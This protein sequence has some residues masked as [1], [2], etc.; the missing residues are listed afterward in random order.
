MST[1]I[2]EKSMNLMEE[3]KAEELAIKFVDAVYGNKLLPREKTLFIEMAKAARL[4]PFTRE[5]HIVAY[6]EGEYRTL[7]IITGYEVY[8]KRAMATGLVEYWNTEIV[9]EDT[10]LPDEDGN[11][12]ERKVY[13]PKCVITIK[14]KDWEKEWKHEISFR[15]FAQFKW[16]KKAG[17]KVLNA[18]WLSKPQFMLKKVGLGQ[19]FRWLF[20][21]YLSVLPYTEEESVNVYQ[22][23]INTEQA[24]TEDTTE[25]KTPKALN[26]PLTAE[27]IAQ[28]TVQEAAD[29]AA[30]N[31]D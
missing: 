2:V 5:I 22:N 9:K 4:N 30:L 28:F 25:G 29:Y 31:Q 24:I 15:E 23:T 12:Q 7:S 11:V 3:S 1:D 21:D 14:R 10:E 13:N 17:K 18:M 27:E 16:D 8:L 6:G 26:T 20:S 19:A